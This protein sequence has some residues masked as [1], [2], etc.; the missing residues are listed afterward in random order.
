MKI[1]SHFLAFNRRGIPKQKY[2][3]DRKKMEGFW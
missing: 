1:S 2:Q 3:F